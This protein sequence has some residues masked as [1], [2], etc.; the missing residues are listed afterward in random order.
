[1]VV[2]RMNPYVWQENLN[3]VTLGIYFS[4]NIILLDFRHVNC[5]ANMLN[6]KSLSYSWQNPECTGTELPIALPISKS[7]EKNQG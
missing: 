7:F 6:G 2:V 5:T 4:I 3:N 1:M